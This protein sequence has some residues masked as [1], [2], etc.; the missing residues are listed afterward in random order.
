VEFEGGNT[1]YPVWSG[2]FWGDGECPA[3]P[4][5]DRMKVLKT[6]TTTITINDTTGEIKV[7]TTSGMTI[8]M[9]SSGIEI[10]NGQGATVKLSGP[11]V[12]LNDSALE[13]I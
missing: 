11:K 10:N 13:V 7:E 9:S 6:D 8:D 4:A 1:D 12:S 3:S 5:N 2:C